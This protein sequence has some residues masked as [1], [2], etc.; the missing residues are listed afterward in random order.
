MKKILI[1]MLIGI[2]IGALALFFIN[3]SWP[4]NNLSEKQNHKGS[5]DS[6]NRE[7]SNVISELDSGGDLFLFINTKK[8]MGTFSKLMV[9][10]SE[11]I[12]SSENMSEI[13]R[14]KT[15]GIFKFLSALFNGSGISDISA[16]GFS[17]IEIGKGV[18]RSKAIIN[19]LPGKNEGLIWNLSNKKNDTLKSIKLLPKKTVYASFAD[20][21]YLKLWSWIKEQTLKSGIK[22]IVNGINSVEPALKNSG[23]D[24]NTLLNSINGDS[25]IIVTFDK[26]KMKSINKSNKQISFPDPAFA[27]IFETQ[28]ES[29]FNLISEKIKNAEITDKD[30]MKM[31]TIKTPPFPITFSPRIIQRGNLLIFS[32]NFEIAKDIFDSINGKNNISETEEFKKLSSGMPE[33]GSGLTFLSSEFFKEIFKIQREMNPSGKSGNPDNMKILKQL[34]FSLDNLSIIKII[35]NSE[36]GLRITTKS[37]IRTDMLMLIPAFA[38]IGIVNAVMLPKMLKKKNLKK[39]IL[40]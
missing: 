22:E 23:I 32:S 3:K 11:S 29:I 31:V 18:F 38:S 12:S 36:S 27:I 30:G 21:N 39:N 7:F 16:V 37:T 8:I 17:S 25:G 35:E 19:H 9:N 40:K 20:I 5:T 28:N 1:G 4:I 34:G 33:A 2:I 26:G 15:K 24:L 13:N 6:V 10:L 14:E